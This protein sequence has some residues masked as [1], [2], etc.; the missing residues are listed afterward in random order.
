MLPE[1]NIR[2]KRNISGSTDKSNSPDISGSYGQ[3]AC[4]A[5]RFA[6]MPGVSD[7]LSS[8]IIA[9]SELKVVSLLRD[10]INAGLPK[11][12]PL[13]TIPPGANPHTPRPH[14]KFSNDPQPRVGAPT[15]LRPQDRFEPRT[16]IHPEP[17][18]ESLPPQYATCPEA[19]ASKPSTNPIQP[20]WKTL[21]WPRQDVAV[22]E[23]KVIRQ[24]VDLIHKGTLLDLFV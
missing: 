11:T 21:P 4:R 7:V 20:P 5:R 23:P 15:V 22:I 2:H 12:G 1:S 13:G 16:V 6:A 17:T 19:G 18:I 24:T 10:A 8:L 9:S 3:P 14:L